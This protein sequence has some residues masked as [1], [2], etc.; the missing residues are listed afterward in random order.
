MTLPLIY[1]LRE[2]GWWERRRILRIVKKD[3]KSRS[4]LRAV[5]DFVESKGGITYARRQMSEHAREAYTLLADLPPT[6]ARDALLDL[7][8]YTVQRNK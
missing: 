3:K 7:V 4:D 5:H 1:A 6:E 2:T 8:H